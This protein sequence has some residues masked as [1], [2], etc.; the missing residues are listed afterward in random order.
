MIR[1]GEQREKGISNLSARCTSFRTTDRLHKFSRMDAGTIFE[2]AATG[3]AGK[4]SRLTA[5]KRDWK[6]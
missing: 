4:H 5:L 6:C 3:S 1:T 2:Q